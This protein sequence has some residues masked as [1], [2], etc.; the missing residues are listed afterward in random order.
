MIMKAIRL[1]IS[2]AAIAAM[3]VACSDELEQAGTNQLAL[4]S[5]ENAV[6]FSTYMG[7][8]SITRGGAYGSIDTEKL[9]DPNYGFGVFAYQ[10]GVDTYTHYRTQAAKTDRYPNFMYN[11]HIVGDGAGGWKYADLR[12]TKY[13]PN[14]VGTEAVDDQNNDSGNDPATTA[15][16]NGGN[17]SFFAYA[18]YADFDYDA[19][20]RIDGIA[21]Q[22]VNDTN[23]GATSGI[24]AFSGNQFN[25]DRTGKKYSDPFLTYRISTDSKKQV[26]LLWGTTGKNGENVVGKEQLGQPSENINEYVNGA[27]LKNNHTTTPATIVRPTFNVNTNL[28]KQKTNGT[29]EFAF[30][31]A[32]AKIGGSYIGAGEGDDED[33]KTPTNGLMVILDIDKDGQELGGSLQEYAEGAKDGT[34]Y[35][36]KVTINEIVLESEKQLTEAGLKA[37]KENS[38]FEYNDTYVEPLSNQGIFNLVTGV[39]HDVQSVGETSRVQDIVPTD[40]DLK[41]DVN[42]DKD[43]EKD[44]V[45]SNE[46]AEPKAVNWTND[47]TKDAFEALPIGVT[48]VAKNVY[49]SDAQP[50]VF[51]PG[52]YPIITITIDYTVRTYDAKL[53]KKYTEVRQKVTKRLYILDK[54]ELNKQYNILMHLGLT[55]VK[56]TASVSDWE[57]VS[58]TGSTTD[59]GD[60]SSPISTF[61]DEVEHVWLPINV[62]G[63]TS[64][65]MGS[66]DY[67][68]PAD[69][70]ITLDE[71]GTAEGTI[72]LGAI[73]FTRADG[74][75]LVTNKLSDGSTIE[76]SVTNLTGVPAG[77]TFA[78]VA[79]NAGSFTITVPENTGVS[80]SDMVTIVV[81][82]PAGVKLATLNIIVPQKGAKTTPEAAVAYN[83]SDRQY[84]GKFTAVDENNIDYDID[85]T[86]VGDGGKN[87]MNDFARILGALYRAGGVKEISFGGNTYTWDE[88]GTLLGSNFKDEAGK[89][90]V[91]AFVEKFSTL[92]GPGQFKLTLGTDRGDITFN[93]HVKSSAELAAEYEYTP[94]YTY[95]GTISCA[96][97]NVTYTI[98]EA[99]AVENGGRNIM[100]DMAR[101][102]GALY[103]NGG[104]TSLTYNGKAYTWDETKGLEGSNWVDASGKTLVSVLAYDY[105]NGVPNGT[106]LK[107]TTNMGDIVFT[108]V[109]E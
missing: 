5:S 35:N 89:T 58:A 50:F 67:D 41:N 109:I 64:V 7:R 31:H 91:A 1:M 100:N 21:G 29:V 69:N 92:L 73:T 83:Y 98:T 102:L 49:E 61:D 86:N 95:K 56:F 82:G 53:A 44:A 17:V 25:G 16:T 57:V 42:N 32:L 46:L 105:R 27:L 85:I 94:A 99:N 39:W 79:N 38:T 103:R 88:A 90:L 51:M 19:N 84:K 104:V 54:I 40:V 47:Y 81:K 62:A 66:K 71:Q 36:T 23:D 68:V 26:D 11:E 18:P 14:E 70:T 52:S 4:N 10:T 45:L 8:S 28:T 37:I 107:L 2:M 15:G 87:I 20:T 72:N 63:I 65:N 101:F 43:N 13:W 106:Q 34:P 60:G 96:V 55:S 9:A 59:P 30:K 76:T 22:A 33:G 80:R 12:N 48:T 24:I 75:E 74:T 97:N 6:N 78:T 93:A 77:Q 108:I 3:T